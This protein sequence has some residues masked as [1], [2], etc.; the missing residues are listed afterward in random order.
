MRSVNIFTVQRPVENDTSVKVL[1][2]AFGNNIPRY[3]PLEG[4]DYKG[5]LYLFCVDS[6]VDFKSI[7][8]KYKYRYYS[9]SVYEFEVN[10]EQ[11]NNNYQ[12]HKVYYTK[13]EPYRL[14]KI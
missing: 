1:S 5:P 4:G 14:E 10:E 6:N 13:E 3:S 12:I 11:Y 9:Y 8:N 2:D 7:C